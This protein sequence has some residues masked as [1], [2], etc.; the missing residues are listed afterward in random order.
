MIGDSAVID[1][2]LLYCADSITISDK[3]MVSA[4]VISE[5]KIVVKD[6]AGLV[7]PTLVFIDNRRNSDCSRAAGA[8]F[9]SSACLEMSAVMIAPT[10][11]EDPDCLLYIDSVARCTGFVLSQPAVDARGT[12]LGSI[13]TNRFTY[14]EAPS[15][16]VNWVHNF[17]VDRTMLDH[18]PPLPLLMGPDTVNTYRIYKQETF[19]Q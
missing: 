13:V 12:V 18:T 11:R 16:Y 10:D 3:A 7:Y 8:F 2:A 17:H 14:D 15:T 9:S 1:G 6:K 4:I 19:L 5:K